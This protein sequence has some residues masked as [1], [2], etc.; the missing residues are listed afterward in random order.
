[1]RKGKKYRGMWPRE[2]GWWYSDRFFLGLIVVGI[3]LLVKLVNVIFG[4]KLL[5]I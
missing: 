2:W 3:L 1:M 5:G 4:L